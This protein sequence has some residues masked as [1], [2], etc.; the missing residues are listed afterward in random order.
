MNQEAYQN[1]SAA[2]IEARYRTLSLRLGGVML[3]FFVAFTVFSVL[4]GIVIPLLTDLMPHP[5]GVV[6][7]ELLYGVLYALCF[8]APAFCFYLFARRDKD[9]QPLDLSF[10]LP[11]HVP[12]YI[13][14]AIAVVSAAGYV[15][16]YLLDL[17]S[18]DILPDLVSVG[19]GATTNVELVLMVFTMAIVPGF[20]EELLFRGVILKNMLPFGRTTA[21]VA[22][23]F[24]FG[25][26]HQNPAQF[27]YT[28]VAGL[29][30][31]YI[32]VHTRSLWCTVI[33]H[34]CNNFLAVVYTVLGERLSPEIHPVVV[35][36]IEL[37]VFLLGGACA[38]YLIL[39]TRR[40]GAEVKRDGAFGHAL[41]TDAEYTDL[42]LPLSRRVK[43]FFSAPMI[44]FLVLAALEM[45]ALLLLN[46]VL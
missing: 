35:L 11:R 44:I 10:S 30:L 24:L 9:Y 28:T 5:Y 34:M 7:Y 6:V 43:L 8:A 4:V 41:A 36:W 13:F 46:M 27:F 25:V 14:V 20:I 3:V 18:F 32:Y 21:V 39:R 40:T 17:I 26:M 42:P 1:Q 12:L 23:A 38:V 29:V 15:N 22:S 33:I 37:F 19:T 31:G 16:S 45:A 2:D